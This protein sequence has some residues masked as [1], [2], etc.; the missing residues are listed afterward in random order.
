M[1]NRRMGLGRM[2]VLLEAVDRDLD[3]ANSTLTNCTITTTAAVAFGGTTIFTR[4][5]VTNLADDGSIP[6]TATCVN[7]DANGSAR[8]GIRFA[9]AG[10]AGQ[11]LIVQN[12]GGENLTFHNTDG[13]SLLR[14][15]E[16]THD[17][18]PTGFCGLFFS[19]GA[20]WNLIAGG[21]DTQPDVGLTAG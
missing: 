10:T 3:L 6:I 9:G 18:M 20:R 7:I 15:T 12:T 14:G 8:T 19:D 21:V 13:T 2:E 5:A 1:G 4:A 11:M 16:A 17:T